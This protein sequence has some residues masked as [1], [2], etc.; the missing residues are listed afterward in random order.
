LRRSFARWLNV[1]LKPTFIDYEEVPFLASLGHA[2]RD[3]TFGIWQYHVA[4]LARD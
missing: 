2:E 1:S 4:Y 3:F